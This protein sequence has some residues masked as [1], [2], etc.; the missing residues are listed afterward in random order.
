MPRF[1]QVTLNGSVIQENVTVSGP[2]RAAGFEDEA[3]TG[4]LMIQEITG[5]LRFGISAT[6][7]SAMN[8]HL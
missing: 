2:T 8:R 1:A 3:P 5:L 7:P 6:A 4:P